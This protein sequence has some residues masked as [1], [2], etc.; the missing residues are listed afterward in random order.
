[1]A[2]PLHVRENW[3]RFAEWHHKIRLISADLP[4]DGDSPWARE[5]AQRAAIRR[6]LTDVGAAD[7]VIVGDLDEIPAPEVVDRLA[8]HLAVPTRLVLRHAMHY[9][10]HEAREPW[11]DGPKACRGNQIDDVGEMGLLLGHPEGRYS[12]GGA[13][14]VEDA[15]W[16]FTNLGGA[17][18]LVAKLGAYSH[19][20]N[21][22]PLFRDRRH[23]D[24]CL[25]LG[26][27]FR[28]TTRLRALPHRALDG[29]QRALLSCEPQLF[30]FERI[31][32]VQAI[33][34]RSYAR[35]RARKYIPAMVVSI[36]DSHAALLLPFLGAPLVLAD[37]ALEVA[38]RRDLRGRLTR[39]AGGL[40]P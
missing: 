19:A 5:R 17:N 2:K 12:P 3:P 21:D 27:D 6:A 4:G 30:R 1:V 7:L 28:G 9:A 37:L 39:F 26:V 31:P 10:N 23:L 15:G 16:H 35:L 24:R 18:A 29:L 32:R 33:V 20:E 34:F 11:T 14:R 22:T 25:A 13:R 40:G 8:V 36:V 38:R